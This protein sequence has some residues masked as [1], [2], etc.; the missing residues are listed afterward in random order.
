[1][2]WLYLL[3][4]GL[5]EIGFAV[6]LK[7]SHGLARPLPAVLFVF[8]SVVSLGLLS[9]AVKALPVG[10]AYAVWT[11]IGTAGTALFGVFVLREPITA[12]RIASLLFIMLGVIGLRFGAGRPG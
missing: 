8:F 6:S 7:A 1:M 5:A 10:T 12:L 11:G 9:Q 2:S 3:G 4:A